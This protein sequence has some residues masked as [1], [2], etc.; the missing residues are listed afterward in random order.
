[1]NITFTYIDTSGNATCRKIDDLES[2][3]I[4]FPEHIDLKVLPPRQAFDQFR[5]PIY[6]LLVFRTELLVHDCREALPFCPSAIRVD[7]C[8]NKPDVRFN[9]RPD[10]FDPSP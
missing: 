10:I 7:I 8:L 1:M 5:R 6:E 2:C 3:E 4:R 9:D